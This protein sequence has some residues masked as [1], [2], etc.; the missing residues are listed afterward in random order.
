[1][2]SILCVLLRGGRSLELRNQAAWLLFVALSL[3]AYIP[4]A[5]ASPEGKLYHY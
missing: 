1:M 4:P 3:S 5:K 2:L